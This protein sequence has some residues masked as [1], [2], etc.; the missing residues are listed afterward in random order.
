MTAIDLFIDA[1]ILLLLA[2]CLWRVAQFLVQRT[3]LRDDYVFQA[4]LLKTVLLITLLSPILGL[5]FASVGN[6]LA[7]D[8]PTTL[9]D[10]AVAAYLS[11]SI[12]MP[13]VEFES[14]LNARR[15]FAETFSAGKVSWASGLALLLALGG[16]VM[17]ARLVRAAL[18]V[19]HTLADSYLW[20]ATRGVDIRLSDRIAVPF[21]A[22][23]LRRRHVVLPS[24]LLTR[25]AELRLVLAHEFAHLRAGDVEWELAL[26]ALR[27]LVFWNPAFV[28]WK[29]A[30]DRLRE[31]SCDQRVIAARRVSPHDYA[32]CLLSFCARKV[33]PAEAGVAR[34]AFVSAAPKAPRRVLEQRILSLYHLPTLRH[35]RA[36][37]IGAGLV[38]AL[39]IG[40]LAAT[41]R[42]PGDWS[43][44]RL[45]LSTIVNLERLDAITRAQTLPFQASGTFGPLAP[46]R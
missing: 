38:L 24:A 23:G 33:A 39:G 21:A 6:Y 17:L 11:G 10:I 8:A 12:S 27:P 45:M 25:P 22:R 1:N 3:P 30:F 20:R 15:T 34:V 5:F 42:Q 14:W 26:E 41:V 13:A 46:S 43:Q 29:R 31:L 32:A 19:Q 37:L 36:M 16:A 44:D 7:P 2:F 35:T 18:R 40:A 28:L 4:G 9:S